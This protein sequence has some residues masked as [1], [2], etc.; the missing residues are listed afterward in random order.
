[1]V[2]KYG[3][4]LEKGGCTLIEACAFITTYTVVTN[5]PRFL[6]HVF[7]RCKPNPVKWSTHAVNAGNTVNG[8]TGWWGQCTKC[9]K[10]CWYCTSKDVPGAA[11]QC[12]VMHTG[13][14]RSA[15]RHG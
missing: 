2:K 9:I 8:G 10:V 14:K 5:L 1:M 7:T 13:A 11:R 3:N 4:Q 15:V 6:L 12:N